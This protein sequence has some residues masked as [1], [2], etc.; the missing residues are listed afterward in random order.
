MKSKDCYRVAKLSNGM[1]ITTRSIKAFPHIFPYKKGGTDWKSI[2]APGAAD[3]EY[4]SGSDD[5]VSDTEV[6]SKSHGSDAEGEFKSREP[7]SEDELYSEVDP[8]PRQLRKRGGL[9]KLRFDQM[10]YDERT[11]K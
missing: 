6:E 10:D 7:D 5:S 11:L 2:P 4:D 8:K 9:K 3:F 1:L